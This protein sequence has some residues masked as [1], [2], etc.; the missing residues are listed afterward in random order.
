MPTKTDEAK[1][2]QVLSLLRA[3]KSYNQVER[4]TGLSRPVVWKIKK[5]AGLVNKQSQKRT[6]GAEPASTPEPSRSASLKQGSGGLD[7][8]QPPPLKPKRAE[9]AAH[10]QAMDPPNPQGVGKVKV[11]PERLYIE[12][13]HCKTGFYADSEDEVPDNCPECGK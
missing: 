7:E 9:L 10:G 2:E 12:C 11:K 1:R 6:V 13:E 5:E 8:F 3:G 4:E